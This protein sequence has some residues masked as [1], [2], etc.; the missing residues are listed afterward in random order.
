MKSKFYKT[1]IY[2]LIYFAIIN[3]VLGAVLAIAPENIILTV[4][5]AFISFFE[6]GLILFSIALI[7]YL[8]VK[9]TTFFYYLLPLLYLLLFIG[10]GFVGSLQVEGKMFDLSSTSN[11]IVYVVTVVFYLL[12]IAFGYYILKNKPLIV[13]PSPK[14]EKSNTLGIVSVVLGVISFIPLIGFLVGIA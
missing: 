12:Q 5:M 6:S 4:L 13:E 8:F 11:L 3:L 14:S 2:L 7:I 1:Y 10:I 9:K